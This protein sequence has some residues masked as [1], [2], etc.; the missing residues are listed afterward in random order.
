MLYV[1]A[2]N[3]NR[4]I[5]EDLSLSFVSYNYFKG[6]FEN[7][8]FYHACLNTAKLSLFYVD[9]VQVSSAS[10]HD[11]WYNQPYSITHALHDMVA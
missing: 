10:N 7:P 1:D 5:L 11:P 6:E 2:S 3:D 8:N 4:S 9:T